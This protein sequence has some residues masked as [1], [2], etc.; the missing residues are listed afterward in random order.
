MER[1]GQ[2]Q[3]KEEEGKSLGE[4]RRKTQVEEAEGKRINFALA[5]QNTPSVPLGPAWIAPPSWDY[6]LEYW[7]S[8]GKAKKWV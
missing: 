8:Q 1:E 2:G 5:E 6:S 7:L 4:E 3:G